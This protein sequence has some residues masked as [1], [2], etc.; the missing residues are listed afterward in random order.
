MKSNKNLN[1]RLNT[2]QRNK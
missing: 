1:E 2:S